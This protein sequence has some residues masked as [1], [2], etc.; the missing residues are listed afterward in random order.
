MNKARSMKQAKLVTKGGAPLPSGKSGWE[1]CQNAALRATAVSGNQSDFTMVDEGFS[2][3]PTFSRVL[4]LFISC[5]NVLIWMPC[6]KMDRSAVRKKWFILGVLQT[7]LL[8]IGLFLIWTWLPLLTGHMSTN[9][10]ISKVDRCPTKIVVSIDNGR[11]GNKFF[12]YLAARFLADAL[13]SDIFITPVFAELYD[14]YFIGRQTPIIDW[15]YLENRCSIPPSEFVTVPV[16]YLPELE[17]FPNITH[18]YN[19][20][21]GK[22]WKAICYLITN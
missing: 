6:K 15:N 12:Q 4:R 22:C 19:K 9:K 11:L 2:R 1:Q 16:N 3:M 8:W 13:E 17:A 20:V 21:T 5:G 7:V 18:K 14:R 10:G